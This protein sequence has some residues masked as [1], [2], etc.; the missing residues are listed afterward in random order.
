MGDHFTAQP[1]FSCLT[2]AGGGADGGLKT[3]EM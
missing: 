2:L 1:I 3:F